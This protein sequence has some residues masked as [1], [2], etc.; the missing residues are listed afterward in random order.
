MMIRDLMTADSLP[1]LE[2]TMR[3]AAQRQRII[4]NN[5][6][7]F[8]TPGFRASDVSVKGFQDALGK[9]IDGRR[10]AHSGVRGALPWKETSELR[11]SDPS[12][13]T[14]RPTEVGGLLYHD[15]GARDLERTMQDLVENTATFQVAAK[16][17]ASR[18]QVLRTAISER[19]A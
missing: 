7:N 16:L 12:R 1:A 19:V 11:G 17:Y 5:I 9:A 3:F 15:Q 2:A 10:D 14:L 8:D 4:S 6:A 13:M 18:M